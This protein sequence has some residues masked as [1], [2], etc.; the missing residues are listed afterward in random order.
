[1]IVLYNVAFCPY[2]SVKMLSIKLANISGYTVDIGKAHIY[3]PEVS[4]LS[5]FGYICIQI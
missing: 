2:K 4:L 5:I 1:M 3:P